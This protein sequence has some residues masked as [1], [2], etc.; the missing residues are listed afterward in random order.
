MEVR[1]SVACRAWAVATSAPVSS[2]VV[3]RADGQVLAFERVRRAGAVAAAAGWARVAARQPVEAVW[4]E[5]GEE[6]GLGPGR[7]RAE[8]ASRGVGRLRV[9]RR[10]SS[11]TGGAAGPGPAVVHVPRPLDDRRSRRPDGREFRAWKWVDPAWLVD[12][13]VAFASG[14]RRVLVE[15]RRDGRRRDDLFRRRPPSACGPR[16][17]SPPGCGRAPSTTSSAR[18]TLLGPGRPLRRLVEQDRLSSVLLWG[19]PG[20][21]KTTLALAVAGTTARAFEQL[22]AVTAGVKDVR[23]VIERARHRLGE[24][25][26]GT[27]L[28][29]DEIHRFTKAQQDALLPAVEDGTLVLIGA[30]TENPFFEVNPPLRSRSTLFRLEPL[31][32]RRPARPR[33]AAGLEAL[34]TTADRRGRRPARRAQR[35]RRTPG[36][37]VARGGRGAGPPGSDR[38][39][40]RR[41]RARHERRALRPRRPLRRDQRVHQVDARL[42]P[43]R[44]RLLAGPDARSRR[45]RP[46]HRPADGDLRQRGRR[47]GRPAGARRRRR[48]RPRRSSSSGCRRRSSTW[49]RPSIHLATAPKSNRARWRSGTPAATS[50][51]ARSARCRR[52]C[53]TPLPGRQGARPRR[54]ATSTLMTTTTTNSA[55]GSTSSTCP[56]SCRTA[57]GTDPAATGTSRRSLERMSARRR[58]TSDGAGDGG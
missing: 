4:R 15:L 45:G 16:R 56:T 10:R 58:D 42:R 46:V 2:P 35:R 54:R 33:R 12:H 1:W 51:T 7:R 32:A 25:G 19:P 48:G 26:Q 30:T 29:L 27:I 57:T 13:V 11:A 41:G 47:H 5:L 39:R 31:D 50:P 36:A 24:H 6:T 8:S 9:A 49:P 37:H 34:G 14:Y 28:F 43:R 21:G 22:S 20:T 23:E 38:A 53:A 40:A 3:R 17:R 44:R 55:A 52:T 18:T